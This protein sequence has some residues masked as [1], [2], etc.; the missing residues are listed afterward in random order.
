[1]TCPDSIEDISQKKCNIIM[2][3]LGS[4]Q[5]LLHVDKCIFSYDYFTITDIFNSYKVRLV[6]FSHEFANFIREVVQFW[7]VRST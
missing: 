1:M 6:H 5:M 7:H 4:G 2:N 3:N